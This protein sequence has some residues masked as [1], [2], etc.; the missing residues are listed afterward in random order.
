MNPPPVSEAELN[1]LFEAQRDAYF[2]DP[3]PTL[4]E[5]Q[6]RL[7]ALK[8][9]LLKHQ[10]AFVESMSKDFGHRADYDSMFADLLPLVSQINYT[11]KRLK[12]WMKPS[13]R[14]AGLLLAPARVS[15]HYQPVGVV[16]IVVPWNFPL[17]LAVGPLITALAA[18]NRALLKMSEFTPH[19]SA[20]L[21]QLLA[22]QFEPTM[23]AVVEGDAEIAAAFTRLPFDHLLF[24]GSTEVGRQ[25]MRA[26]AEHLTPLTL[27]LGGKSPVLIG[28]DMPVAQAV[29]RMLL[30]KCMNAGQICVAPDYVL[31]D[32][33]RVEHFVAEFKRQFGS[34]YP[35]ARREQ[36]YTRVINQRQWQRLQTWL[37]EARQQGATVIPAADTGVVL[38]PEARLM[39]PHLIIGATASM[40]VMQQELFGPLLLVECY[41]R[42]DDAIDLIRQRPRP[43]ACYLMSDDRELQ[44]RFVER[45]HA[46]GMCI[47]EAMLH[48]AAD[49]APFGGIGPS[50]M[51]HYHGHEG[52]LSM[53]KAKTVLRR[54][55]LNPTQLLKPPY[56]RWWQRLMLWLFMR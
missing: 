13:R 36:D 33:A 14:H 5:R 49:D 28:P 40:R 37:E 34:A 47:N 2:R 35:A 31:I 16:G 48:V 50:G 53:S 43:L 51:G 11:I 6:R 4:A 54:G 52:F 32:Q 8:A 56:H 25:V 17:M 1:T 55:K 9:L 3:M 23:V 38:D 19:T 18:G 29:S 42:V 30:A 41:Q 44:Q 12:R 26:A 24:T 15:V 20:L 7:Q 10:Q 45:V 27:E 21:K 39:I 22:E 46:G